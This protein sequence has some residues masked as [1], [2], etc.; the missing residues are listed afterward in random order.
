MAG[1]APGFVGLALIA[2]WI[3]AV[4]DVITTDRAMVRNL[5]KSL[6]LFLV[7]FVPMLGAI[8]WLAVGRPVKARVSSSSTGVQDPPRTYAPEPRG[9]EDSESWIVDTTKSVPNDGF[10]TTAARERRLLAALEADLAKPKLDD[11]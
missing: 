8:G 2:L 6:W 4:F 7:I 9:P 10:E 1:F 3:C 11:D 5:D